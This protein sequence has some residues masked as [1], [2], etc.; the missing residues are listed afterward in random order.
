MP[1]PQHSRM[2]RAELERLI[3]GYASADYPFVFREYAVR[4]VLFFNGLQTTKLTEQGFENAVIVMADK[5]NVSMPAVPA[6]LSALSDAELV[7][8]ADSL[9]LAL[10]DFHRRANALQ[11]CGSFWASAASPPTAVQFRDMFIRL[12]NYARGARG[13]SPIV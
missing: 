7:T 5:L 10:W 9:E 13:L 2:G 12:A 3:V 11:Y 1:G 6:D 8:L 4:A